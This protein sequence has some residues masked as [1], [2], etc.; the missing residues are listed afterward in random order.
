MS[1]KPEVA[2]YRRGSVKARERLFVLLALV[3]APA[4]IVFAMVWLTWEVL[5][6][7]FKK[8]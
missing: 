1:Q 4:L 3:A 5:K 6:T 7:I 8:L 2:W